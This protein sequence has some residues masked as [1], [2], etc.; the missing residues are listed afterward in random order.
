M[1]LLKWGLYSGEV[2][3][4]I[5]VPAAVFFVQLLRKNAISVAL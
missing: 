3:V 2:R 1:C 4:Q 5:A